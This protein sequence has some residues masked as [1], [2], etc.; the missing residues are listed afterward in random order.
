MAKDFIIDFETFGNVSSSSVID[1]A[2][3]TFDS[4]PEVLESFGEFLLKKRLH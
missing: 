2:L 3:I 1:L 4:D